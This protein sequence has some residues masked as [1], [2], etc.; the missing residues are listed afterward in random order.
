MSFFLA[1]GKTLT[2]TIA[3]EEGNPNVTSLFKNGL[4]R[5]VKGH[6]AWKSAAKVY[7]CVWPKAD[8]RMLVQVPLT[9]TAAA[10][11]LPSPCTPPGP[12]ASCPSQGLTIPVRL[13]IHSLSSKAV[14][15]AAGN[16]AQAYVP[17]F[18][19]FSMASRDSLMQRRST[20]DTG[21]QGTGRS[22]LAQVQ[23]LLYRLAEDIVH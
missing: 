23:P 22:N 10:G 17:V 3:T 13:Q 19:P 9:Q 6:K 1:L 14:L 7:H 5:K 4:T 11:T 21:M 18:V 12:A 16:R 20:V 2:S 8:H 15:M